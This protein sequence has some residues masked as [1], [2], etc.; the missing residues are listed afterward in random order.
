ML[1]RSLMICTCLLLTIL[2]FAQNGEWTRFK[3]R[4]GRVNM[5]FPCDPVEESSTLTGRDSYNINCSIGNELYSLN[6]DIYYKDVGVRDS[7]PLKL[8]AEALDAFTDAME[9]EDYESDVFKHKKHQGYK[10]K[11]Q[12]ED[13]ISMQY[14]CI[15]IGQTLY[16]LIFFGDGTLQSD[17]RGEKFL[18]SFNSKAK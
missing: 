12:L 1:Q 3:S 8:A 10:T 2:T 5:Q 17:K 7:D 13:G 16:Q 14:R 11:V 18:N 15:V 6:F 9:V 4:V